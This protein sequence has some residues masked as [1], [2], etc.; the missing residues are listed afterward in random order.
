[1]TLATIEVRSGDHLIMGA[2]DRRSPLPPMKERTALHP[3]LTRD[4]NRVP[5]VQQP[6]SLASTPLGRPAYGGNY[7]LMNFNII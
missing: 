2:P 5:L 1:M 4:S 6:A 3:C 7:L